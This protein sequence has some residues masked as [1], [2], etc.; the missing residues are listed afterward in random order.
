MKKKILITKNDFFF[1]LF[2]QYWWAVKLRLTCVEVT[3][4]KAVFGSRKS[5][6]VTSF[7]ASRV[8]R[9]CVLRHKAFEFTPV[10]SR[11]HRKSSIPLCP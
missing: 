5:H 9:R 2:W 3:A 11:S 8:T 6:T 4:P 1:F 7:S 10:Q